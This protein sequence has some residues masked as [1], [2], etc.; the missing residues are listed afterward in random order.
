MVRDRF[1]QAIMSGVDAWRECCPQGGRQGNGGVAGDFEA[2][3]YQ[4][5][6]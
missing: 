6:S 1:E 5:G 3:L 4:F 2:Q